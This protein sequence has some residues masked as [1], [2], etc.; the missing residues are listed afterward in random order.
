MKLLILTT[1][2]L[3]EANAASV[4]MSQIVKRFS[5]KDKEYIEHIRVIAF[6]PL[7]KCEHEKGV[8][9]QDKVEVIRH[10]RRILPAFVFMPQ[11]LNPLTLITWIYIS[12]KEIAKYNPDVLL[13][14][15]PPFAPAIA[16][17]IASRV[18]NKP[19]I[20]D[21]RDDLTSV[22]YG[23]AETKRFYTK[24]PLKVANKF[25]SALLFHSLKKALLISTVNEVLRKKLLDL[26]RNVITV[27]NGIDIQE[28]NEVKENFDKEK[29]LDKNGI[30]YSEGSMILVY[31]G[32]LNMPYYMPEI[33]LEPLKSLLKTGYNVKYIIIGDGKRREPIEKIRKEMG[34]EDVVFLVGKKEHCEVLELL[35]ACDAAFYSL[36]K[37]DPQAKHAIGAKVYEYIGCGLPILVLSDEGSAVSELVKTHDIGVFV[38]WDEIDRMGNALRKLLESKK[39]ARNIQLHYSYFIEKFD[40]NRGIDLLYDNVKALIVECS[41]P[42]TP[43]KQ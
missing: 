28:L 20:V 1:Y 38:S 14:T 2:Y 25:M 37:K 42:T 26:N 12:L 11:S 7:Y 16:S 36:Q 40:R 29:V 30:S 22:I 27:P 33:I 5:Y 39:Y 21:Y 17:C 15:T 24:Y 19:Y 32:D 43:K 3:P 4:R 34:L 41:A 18:L 10:T 8:N 23:I 13:T 9:E 31:V 6:N 35:L